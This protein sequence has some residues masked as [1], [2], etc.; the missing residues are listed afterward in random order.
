MNAL[1][2]QVLLRSWDQL[3]WAR[4]SSNDW[5]RV[6]ATFPL[7]RGIGRRRLRKLVRNARFVEH[8]AG[9][10]IIQRDV[11]S[12]SLYVI[13]GGS[14][15]AR[16]RSATRSL[17]IGD[18]FGEAGLLN[19][20]PGAATVVA[21]EELHVMRLPRRSYVRIARRGPTTSFAMLRNVGARLRRLETETAGC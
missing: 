11:P 8:A 18:Y 13:V 19:G 6:L 2:M 20:G 17:H 16:G 5:A 14:A 7:F 12:D 3:Y 1:E 10:A 4:A 9:D 15:T 21:T